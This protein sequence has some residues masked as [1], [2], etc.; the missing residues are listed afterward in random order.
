MI[1]WIILTALAVFVAMVAVWE[2]DMYYSPKEDIYQ[3]FCDV[4]S[5]EYASRIGWTV[6]NSDD[7][8]A[9]EEYLSRTNI[10]AAEAVCSGQPGWRWRWG[11][12]D[13]AGSG[14][15]T[16][17]WLSY[18]WNNEIS[19]RLRIAEEPEALDAFMLM[20]LLADFCYATRYSIYF[21]IYLSN[22]HSNDSDG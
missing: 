6:N 8:E 13:S 21:I 19:V 15:L 17:D 12:V 18:A 2:F 10:V 7:S 16:E 1:G 22:I 11:D 14:P 20:K 3:E 5:Y 4:V 9:I